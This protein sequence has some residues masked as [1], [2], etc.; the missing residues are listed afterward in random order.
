MTGHTEIPELVRHISLNY[1]QQVHTIIHEIYTPDI[2]SED[3]HGT[4]NRPSKKG[5]FIA[6]RI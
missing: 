6:I 1:R 5:L 2:K 3:V 4:I